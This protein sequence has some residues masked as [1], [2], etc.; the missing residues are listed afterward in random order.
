[1]WFL[2]FFCNLNLKHAGNIWPPAGPL[3]AIDAESAIAVKCAFR[4]FQFLHDWCVRSA[5][6]FYVFKSRTAFMFSK[7]AR[8]HIAFGNDAL[9]QAT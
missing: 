5:H 3:K 7:A 1:M 6:S 2:C 8:L 9:S 4:N